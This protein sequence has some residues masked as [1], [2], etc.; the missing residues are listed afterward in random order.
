MILIGSQGASQKLLRKK[1]VVGVKRAACAR[2]E[3]SLTSSLDPVEKERKRLLHIFQQVSE[4]TIVTKL[5][6]YL[7]S[8]TATDALRG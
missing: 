8:G 4:E 5:L 1:K 2:G 7:S 6:K 3:P